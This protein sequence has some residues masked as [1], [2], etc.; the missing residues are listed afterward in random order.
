MIAAL[1]VHYREQFAK[2]VILMFKQWNSKEPTDIFD[3]VIKDIHPY[4]P[5]EFYKRELPCLLELLS[6]VEINTLD[7]VI[8]DGFVILDKMGKPGLGGYLYEALE[9]K[10]PVIGVAKTSFHQCELFAEKVF[11]GKSRNPLFVTSK[12]ILPELGAEHVKNM[13]G[14]YRIPHLLK[15]LDQHTKS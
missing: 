3:I 8:I 11:R 12:G 2:A 13:Y 15:I 1:D 6:I 9:E 7:A 10:I 4:V 14:D 5:G